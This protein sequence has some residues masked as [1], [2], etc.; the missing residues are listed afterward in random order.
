MTTQFDHT[1]EG[2]ISRL[3]PVLPDDLEFVYTVSS[4]ERNGFRWRYRGEFPDLTSFSRDHDR[5]TLL[6]LLVT[7]LHSNERAGI[8]NL[9][10]ENLRDGWAYLGALSA[11]EFQQSGIVVDG[12]AT[13]MDYA[14]NLWPFRKIYVE[15][16]EYNLSEFETGLRRVAVEEGR[17]KDHV[18]FGDRHWDVVTSAVYRDMWRDYRRGHVK[19]LE[20]HLDGLVS[21]DQFRRLLS[22]QLDLS[23]LSGDSLLIEDLGID[24]LMMSELIVTVCDLADAPDPDELPNLETFNDVYDWY[25]AMRGVRGAASTGS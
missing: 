2:R 6:Q 12:A 10:G 19:P 23:V 9:Y 8:V 17:L 7:S 16:I 24:S 20:E 22:E 4:C 3:R 5:G 21:F 13:L 11:P 1:L 25:L 18:F 15:T 14:F